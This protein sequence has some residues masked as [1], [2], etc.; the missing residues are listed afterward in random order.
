MEQHATTEEL[1]ARWREAERKLVN[2]EPDS[3]RWKLLRSLADLDWQAY[4]R[5]LNDERQAAR[6]SGEW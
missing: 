6:Q 4:E 5:R 3:A 2:I 1:L